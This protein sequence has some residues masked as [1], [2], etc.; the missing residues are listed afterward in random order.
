MNA[1]SASIFIVMMIWLAIISL[2][3]V[4]FVYKIRKSIDKS[5]QIT[6]E[7][8]CHNCGGKV[9]KD[10]NFCHHCGNPINKS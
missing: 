9:N 6:Y 4:F 10:K 7:V 3:V 8:I 2:I 5:K 1:E